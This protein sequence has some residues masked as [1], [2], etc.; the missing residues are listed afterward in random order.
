[1]RD[2][3]E[4]PLIGGLVES[5]AREAVRPQAALALAAM[6]Y[7]L[8]S[9]PFAYLLGRARGVD[10]RKL[11]S[12]NVGATNLGRVLGRRWGILAFILDFLKGLL[13]VAAANLAAAPASAG[14]GVLLFH[15]QMA[16]A[17]A[18]VL[19]HVFPIYL[20]FRG[21]KG[22]ATSFGAV[23]G[24][25][26]LAALLAGAVWLLVFLATRTVSLASIAAAFTFP[27]A[28]I[29]I[30]WSAPPSVAVP[31]GC[32]AAGVGALIVARHG[33]NIRRLLAGRENRF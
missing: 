24:L 22:V 25:S 11:G 7:L 14:A 30:F 3:M 23:T 4:L 6:A 28:T 17:L 8:G 13:P 18:A 26:W 21:G 10:I 19:G 5:G 1:M 2:V 20:R 9:V 29:I 31:M 15:A 16:C 32:L 12:G 33:S 27:I